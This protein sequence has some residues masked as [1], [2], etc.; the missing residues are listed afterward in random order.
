M[1]VD[2]IN[3]LKTYLSLEE[4]SEP[5]V[6]YILVEIRKILENEDNNMYPLLRF[7]CNW[8]LHPKI[9]RLSAVRDILNKIAE[10]HKK[11]EHG[12]TDLDFINFIHLNEELKRF[13]LEKNISTNLL[14]DREKWRKFKINLINILK[15]CPLEVSSDFKPIL[16]EKLVLKKCEE[17]TNGQFRNLD[18]D[19]EYKLVDEEAPFYSSSTESDII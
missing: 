13:F 4:Y 1:E 17:S 10:E 3:K 19:W 2:I 16:V 9:D 15:D 14:N 6:V 18:I 5:I 11:G 8:V 7:Y 12:K